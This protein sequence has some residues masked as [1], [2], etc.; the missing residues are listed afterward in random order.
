MGETKKKKSCVE[1]HLCENYLQSTCESPLSQHF[2]KIV[3]VYE[4]KKIGTLDERFTDKFRV[5]HNGCQKEGI[6]PYFLRFLLNI[7]LI[8]T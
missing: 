1:K 7:I 3:D 8:Q 5:R 2:D 4:R 6:H